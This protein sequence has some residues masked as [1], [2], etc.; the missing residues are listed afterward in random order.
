MSLKLKNSNIIIGSCLSAKLSI[1]PRKSIRELNTNLGLNIESDES[2][3][4]QVMNRLEPLLSNKVLPVMIETKVSGL[5][6]KP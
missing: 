3:C 1:E 5:I 2:I 6:P 4:D